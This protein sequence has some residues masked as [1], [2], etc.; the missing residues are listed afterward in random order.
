ML[1]YLD[2]TNGEIVWEMKESQYSP[3]YVLD[4]DHQI[5]YTNQGEA[6]LIHVPEQKTLWETPHSASGFL[7]PEDIFVIKGTVWFGATR[8]GRG[9]GTFT[10]VNL[11][12]GKVETTFQPDE[13]SYWF[14]QRCYP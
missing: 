13:K 4:R 12:T 10:G 6:M 8:D 2:P 7:S 1:T 3:G 11:K 5:F 14:H 9:K